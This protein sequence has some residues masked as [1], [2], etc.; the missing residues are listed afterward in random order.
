VVRDAEHL[1]RGD[2]VA[3]AVTLRLHL[4]PGTPLLLGDRIQIQQVLVNLILNAIEATP[5]RSMGNGEVVVRTTIVESAIEIGVEDRGPGL[6][7]G[8]ETRIFEP[9]YSTKSD[10][11]GMGLSISRSIVDAHGGRFRASNGSA[12]GAVF[13]F[14]LALAPSPEAPLALEPKSNSPTQPDS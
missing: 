12:G 6:P 4:D 9:F 14:T 7:E 13:T 1:L 3:H 2:A 5:A 8:F 11:M 10:G